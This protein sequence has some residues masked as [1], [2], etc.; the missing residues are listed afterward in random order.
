M[1]KIITGK[2]G[3][4]KTKTLIAQVNAAAE[5][6][7]GN[8]ICVE[9]KR[10]LTTQITSRARLIATE[11]YGIAGYDAFYGF[12]G[13]LCAGNYDITDIFVD[14]TLRI[15]GRHF[16]ELTAFLRRAAALDCNLV[17]TISADIEEL[18]EEILAFC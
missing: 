9:Q 18:P 12:L 15:G 8:V 16:G 11:D 17:F 10:N 7:P 1:V 5:Q 6:S 13:G 3:S 2:K 14:A 4:G